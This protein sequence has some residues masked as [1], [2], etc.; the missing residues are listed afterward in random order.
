MGMTGAQG[1]KYDLL[2]KGQ[3]IR[4]QYLDHARVLQMKPYIDYMKEKIVDDAKARKLKM[5]GNAGSTE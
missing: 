1:G 2:E 4:F 3:Q 5:S